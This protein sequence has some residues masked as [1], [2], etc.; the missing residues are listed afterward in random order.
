MNKSVPH[1]QISSGKSSCQWM[2]AHNIF[3][4]INGIAAFQAFKRRKKY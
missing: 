4:G 2:D 1:H 3:I